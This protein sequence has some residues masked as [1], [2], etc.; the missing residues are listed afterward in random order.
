MKWF[1]TYIFFSLSSAEKG[2][3]MSSMV[4]EIS[5]F[6]RSLF[7]RQKN[8]T[9]FKNKNPNNVWHVRFSAQRL[10]R[11]KCACPPSRTPALWWPQQ[12]SSHLVPVKKKKT[13]Q[14]GEMLRSP[15]VGVWGGCGIEWRK[16]EGCAVVVFLVFFVGFYVY[17]ET[18]TR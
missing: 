9:L 1:Q 5:L 17:G 6:W 12:C 13:P 8:P 15:S 14:V 11:S 7:S 18:S 4:Q 3:F 2:P 16:K 10:P